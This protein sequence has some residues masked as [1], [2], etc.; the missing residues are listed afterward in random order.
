VTAYLADTSAW[1]RSGRT[2]ILERWSELLER[3]ALAICSPV[4][5]ELLHSAKGRANF[6]ALRDDL[7]ALPELTFDHEA[8]RRAE[9]VQ[10]ELAERGQHRGAMSVDLYIA[11]IAELNGATLL[12]YDRH[13]D[14]IVRITG[15]PAEW[16]APRGS[17]D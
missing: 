3:Q 14:A 17:V 7:T 12:H 2:P 16:I 5:L 15:Q 11:A 13:F 4:R 9:G 6:E 8:A 10:A 1:H